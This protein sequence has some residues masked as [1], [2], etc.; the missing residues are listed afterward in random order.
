MKIYRSDFINKPGHKKAE[1][2]FRFDFSFDVDSFVIILISFLK[3]FFQENLRKMNYEGFQVGNEAR[4]TSICTYAFSLCEIL[5][6]RRKTSEKY[7]NVKCF[8]M[9]NC[10]LLIVLDILCERKKKIFLHLMCNCEVARVIFLHVFTHSGWKEEITIV[11]ERWIAKYNC[12]K[13]WVLLWRSF[14]C[15]SC[16]QLKEIARNC[17]S[18]EIFQV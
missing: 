14:F 12:C 4:S 9:K 3:L 6:S 11:N 16:F 13:W 2:S 17:A 15:L 18:N 7:L 10:I 8:C 1:E 5:A